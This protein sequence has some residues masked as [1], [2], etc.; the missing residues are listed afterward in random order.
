MRRWPI[1]LLFGAVALFFLVQPARADCM[2]SCMINKGCGNAYQSGRVGGYCETMQSDCEAYCHGHASAAYGALAY[3]TRTDK[4]GW[5]ASA[6]TPAEARRG[7]LQA[8]GAGDCRVAVEFNN[9]CAA[10]AADLHGNYKTATGRTATEVQG[11]ALEYCG[12]GCDVR[13]WSC[14]FPKN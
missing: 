6:G 14:S 8:C 13:V 2:D 5:S 4:A 11:L 3:S 9:A 1:P 12:R 7:A 10:L